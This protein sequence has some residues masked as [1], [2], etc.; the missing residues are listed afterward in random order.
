[1]HYS[2]S[3]STGS[4][5]PGTFPDFIVAMFVVGSVFLLV[6]V[7]FVVSTISRKLKEKSDNSERV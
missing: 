1:V 4:P 6:F 5:K 7:I 2:G 3:N